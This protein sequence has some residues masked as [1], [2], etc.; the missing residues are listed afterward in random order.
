MQSYINQK[1]SRNH[2]NSKNIPKSSNKISRITN[3]T[4]FTPNNK[5]YNFF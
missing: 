1:I 4:Y 2:Q 3:I 5:I